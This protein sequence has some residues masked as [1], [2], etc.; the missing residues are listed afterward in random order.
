MDETP[1]ELADLQ[2][3]IDR[4]FAAAG[5]HLRAIVRPERRLT[6]RQVAAYLQG[7][8]HIA[9]GTV[10]ASG[11]PRV[12]PVDG[13]FWHGY[14]HFSTAASSVRARHLAARP[15]VS[16]AHVV[17]DQV[18]FWTYGRAQLVRPGDAVW[19]AF[20]ERWREVYG[21]GAASD[22]APDPVYVRIVPERFFAYAFVA[23]A[24]PDQPAAA[25]GTRVEHDTMGEV[26]VPAGA[27]Y[28]AQ[29]QR[30]VENFPVSGDR[31]PVE[32]VHA[33]A[34]I[35]EAAAATNA[36][37][38]VLPRDTAEAVALAARSVAAGDH[39]DQFPV[40]VFQTG[41]GTSTNMN[42]NEVL[43]TLASRS[44]DRPVHPNDDVNASQSSNDDFPSAV[45]LAALQSARDGLLP[46]LDHLAATFESKATELADVVKAGRTHLM[47]AVPVTV[48]QELHGYA[49]Q[50]RRGAERIVAALP[51]VAELPLGGTAVGTGLNTPPG[52][53]AA[54]VA[55]LAALTG[56]PV[57]AAQ[58][59]LEAQSARDALVELSGQLRVLAVSLTKIC[60]DL[61]WMASG[62]R[63]GLGELHLPDLQPGSSIMPGKVNP[64]VPE[65][66]LQV[67]AQVVGNDTAVAWGGAAGTFELNVMVP[68][69]GRN[70]LESLRLLTSASRLLADRCVAGIAADAEHALA[71]A[72][73]SPAIATGLNTYLGYE[74]VAA[75][76]KQSVAQRRTIRDVVVDR[77][78]VRDGRITQEQ[79]D[80]A[81][82]VRRMARQRE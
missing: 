70:L 81:L 73:S 29:T 61:R 17:G 66:V 35:K 5:D 3:L 41:S 78:H 44:L 54:V 64:V 51:R 46:A 47:D 9:V 68:V 36:A 21:G 32:L 69:I 25:D 18:A 42:V 6:A 74:E 45:H 23:S 52:W 24:V 1:A 22:W 63:A 53:R 19:E 34:R 27:L 56:Q 43:A 50:V 33:L 55:E 39:D 79:L 75:V 20:E 8:K 12:A 7:V 72:E 30:A 37:M 13:L 10:T 60:N 62:P 14:F 38:G 49:T 15:A 57:T 48:G 59:G 77:G 2:E 82:D 11:Q 26:R 28:R 4:S 65:A 76:V 71:L 67:C 40:D 16:A 80:E 58:D 31:V